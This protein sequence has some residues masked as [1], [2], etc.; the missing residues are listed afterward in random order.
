M[1]WY[2]FE[3][4]ESF[5]QWHESLKQRLGYPLPAL[6]SNGNITDG[7]ITTDYTNPVI[8][9]ENDVRAW[10]DEEYSNNLVACDAPPMPENVYTAVE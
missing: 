2:T 5:N 8:V 1:G 6:D 9:L 10:V 4:I 3:N 7:T